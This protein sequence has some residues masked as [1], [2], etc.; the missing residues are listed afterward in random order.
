[1]KKRLAILVV[2]LVGAIGL[3]GCGSGDPSEARYDIRWADGTTSEDVTGDEVRRRQAAVGGY[4]GAIAELDDILRSGSWCEAL[5]EQPY[6]T[7]DK[8][9]DAIAQPHN[10]ISVTDYVPLGKIESDVHDAASRACW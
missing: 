3:A 1:M 2:P 9:V 8:I 6:E 4:E 7:I 5:H 10:G